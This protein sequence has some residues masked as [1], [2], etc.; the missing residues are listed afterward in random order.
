MFDL[1]KPMEDGR[2][3]NLDGSDMFAV[4][5]ENK[6]QSAFQKAVGF[7]KR[8]EILVP[9]ALVV[10]AASTYLDF[11]QQDLMISAAKIIFFNILTDQTTNLLFGIHGKSNLCIDRDGEKSV[12]QPIHKF[13]SWILGVGWASAVGSNTVKMYAEYNT[14]IKLAGVF[15]DLPDLQNNLILDGAITSC[16]LVNMWRQ[17][18]IISNRWNVID[19]PPK[20]E[21]REVRGLVPEM[22]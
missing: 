13:L 16:L 9:F 2:Y 20:Q 15:P 7:V 19:N 21:K 8:P 1:I 4:A 12:T 17:A 5:P 22:S 10:G 14:G 6:L 18:N 3:L 11:S